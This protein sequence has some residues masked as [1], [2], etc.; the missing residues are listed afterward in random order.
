MK[1]K[2]VSWACIYI[3]R[4]V[5]LLIFSNNLGRDEH[6][7]IPTHHFLW[8]NHPTWSKYSTDLSC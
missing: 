4:T 3:R 5:C 7:T 8:D 2:A 6:P 1:E